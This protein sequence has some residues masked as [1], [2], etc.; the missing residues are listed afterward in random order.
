MEK[1]RGGRRAG[2]GRKASKFT[3]LRRRIE[4]EKSDDAEYAFSL[5]AEVMRDDEQPLDL[6]LSCADWIANRVLGRPKERLEHSGGDTPVVFNYAVIDTLLT[7]RPSGDTGA[8]R[9]N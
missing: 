6:R 3:E 5:Y 1:K 9:E 4:Q 2:A 8:P 7:P